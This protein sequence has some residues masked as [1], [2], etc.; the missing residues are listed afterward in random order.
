M[1]G[2]VWAETP[3]LSSILIAIGFRLL[4][5]ATKT[6]KHH[7]THQGSEEGNLELVILRR[8]VLDTSKGWILLT[9][10]IS[11]F[12]IGH[13]CLQKIHFTSMILLLLL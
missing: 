2:P 5:K 12:A 13:T 11:L 7:R 4:Y 10:S 8:K 3:L 9:L 1:Y 6:E